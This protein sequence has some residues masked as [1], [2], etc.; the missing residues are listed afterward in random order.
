MGEREERR[1]G[2]VSTILIAGFIVA[3]IRVIAAM[4]EIFVNLFQYF[5]GRI[6]VYLMLETMEIEFRQWMMASSFLALRFLLLKLWI[7]IG[8]KETSNKAG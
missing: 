3:L 2:L 4:A 7:R 5:L 8:E 6:N 1:Y